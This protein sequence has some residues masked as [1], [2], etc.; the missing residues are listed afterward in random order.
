MYT[1]LIFV[2]ILLIFSVVPIGQSVWKNI[3]VFLSFALA[4]LCTFLLTLLFPKGQTHLFSKVVNK[5]YQKGGFYFE[6]VA[7]PKEDVIQ[8]IRFMLF[9]IIFIILIYVFL[10]IFHFII[11]ERSPFQKNK[12]INLKILKILFVI[13]NIGFIATTV[14]FGCSALA[15]LWDFYGGF[16]NRLFISLG[17]VVMNV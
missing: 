10:G 11:K 4:F 2:V 14:A 9:F 8:I 17:N 3:K 1:S 15:P 13:C 7:L 6:N 12:G 5:I 16:L